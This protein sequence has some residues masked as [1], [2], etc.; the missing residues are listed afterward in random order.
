[1]KKKV[2]FL[3]AFLFWV[4]AVCTLLALRIEALMTPQVVLVDE[5]ASR[6]SL[7]TD[8]VFT[9]ESGPHVF[10]VVEGS[11]WNSGTLAQEVPTEY[12]SLNGDQLA[13]YAYGD[14]VQYATKQPRDRY[15]V[16]VLKYP[17]T[18]DDH[19]LVCT[20]ESPDLLENTKDIS[21][22]QVSGDVLLLAVHGMPSPFM[23]NRAK[24]ILFEETGSPTASF[25]IYSM[26]EVESF[27]RTL[28]LLAL[29]V[30]F[31]LASLILWGYSC[32]LI[33]NARK[34]RTALLVNGGIVAAFFAGLPFLLNRVE[35]PS[36]LLPQDN[37]FD[38][39]HYGKEVSDIFSALQALAADGSEVAAAALSQAQ[40][41]LWASLAVALAGAALGAVIVAVEY[42]VDRKR[43]VKRKHAR[44][45]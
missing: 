32:R 31:L 44:M 16:R 33:K 1:M 41:A 34:D 42:F 6:N 43:N 20:E 2:I 23:Q 8:C 24:T 38:F 11:G 40:T 29:L 30:A 12:Y 22:E 17:Q 21:V 39:A 45:G 13:L 7:P 37:I 10:T 27:L 19:W 15:P 26:N 3:F 4:L 9:D 5:H 36:S 28:P 14:P 25:T 18:A 35:L